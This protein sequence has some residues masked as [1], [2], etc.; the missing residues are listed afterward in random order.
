MGLILEEKVRDDPQTVNAY[1]NRKVAR[2]QKDSNTTSEKPAAF[3]VPVFELDGDKF[4]IVQDG[5]R[6]ETEAEAQ[7]L[8]IRF[9]RKHPIFVLKIPCRGAIEIPPGGGV[10]FVLMTTR[11]GFE[12][13]DS[14]LCVFEGPSFDKITHTTG[15]GEGA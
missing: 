10:P 14:M 1:L 12:T 6:A 7:E 5:M 4:F 8:G 11:F 2:R 3:W 15:A 9:R 13:D